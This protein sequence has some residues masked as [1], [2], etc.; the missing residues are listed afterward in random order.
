MYDSW[1][2]LNSSCLLSLPEH[3]RRS[4][5]RQ[6]LRLDLEAHRPLFDAFGNLKSY[7]MRM[8]AMIALISLPAN[9][10]P[11]H[12]CRPKPNDMLAKL[13]AAYCVRAAMSAD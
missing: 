10:L 6:I 12:A 11:G 2:A 13:L 1:Q 7:S 4:V 5:I 9:H 8:Y 3:Q